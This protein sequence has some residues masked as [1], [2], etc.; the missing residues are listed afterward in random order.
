MNKFF[1]AILLIFWANLSLAQQN[2]MSSCSAE[3]VR[4]A[5]QILVNCS[6]VTPPPVTPQPS[7]T[8]LY[9]SDSCNE[10]DLIVNLR[11]GTDCSSS[12]ISSAP[13]TWGVLV[14]GVCSDIT[15]EDTPKACVKFKAAGSAYA[16]FF[17]HSDSCQPSELIAA[18]DENT[19]CEKLAQAEN[20]RVWGVVTDGKCVDI[21]D[22]DLKVACE[23]YKDSGIALERAKKK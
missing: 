17:Y 23:R 8:A 15:D 14:R 7:K 21:S 9:H 20:D 2:C 16:T 6:G 3:C 13:R 4:A 18:V 12:V 5:Q 22:A 1:I 11:S 10:G 19:D